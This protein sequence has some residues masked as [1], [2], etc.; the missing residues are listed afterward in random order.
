MGFVLAFFSSRDIYQV[1]VWGY[2]DEQDKFDLLEEPDVYI[3]KLECYMCK[4]RAMHRL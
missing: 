2:K 4:D 1:P 3:K